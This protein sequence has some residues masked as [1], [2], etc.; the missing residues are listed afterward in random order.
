MLFAGVDAGGTSTRV[1]VHTASGARV[2]YGTARRGNP[3][4]QGPAAAAE[5]IASALRRAIDGLPAATVTASVAG[6]A[7][8]D[9]TFAPVLC[10]I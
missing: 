1:A 6:V 9:D 3:A 5:A 7:G 10:R 4:A 2:G 8:A